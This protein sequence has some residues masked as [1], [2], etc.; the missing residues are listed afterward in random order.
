MHGLSEGFDAIVYDPVS[1]HMVGHF[2]PFG[3]VLMGLIA[4]L[5]FIMVALVLSIGF[6]GKG[7]RNNE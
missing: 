2:S 1:F 5:P 7:V 6:F 3:H 4:M